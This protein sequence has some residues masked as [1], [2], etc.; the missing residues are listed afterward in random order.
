M[1]GKRF[2][3]GCMAAALL[4]F[5]SGA[6]ALDDD[7]PWIR[8]G[9]GVTVSP[10]F[11]DMTDDY[12]LDASGD[13]GW[14]DLNAGLEFPV[15]PAIS[16]IPYVAFYF[17]QISGDDDSFNIMI[18]PALAAKFIMGPMSSMTDYWYPEADFDTFIQLEVNY[19][20]PHTSSDE[21]EMDSAGFGFAGLL[22]IQLDYGYDLAAGYSYI[23]VE[24]DFENNR[25]LGG[26]LLRLNKSF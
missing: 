9:A 1:N 7:S 8:L 6:Q 22:G 3:L 18:V 2:A 19:G 4:A 23:P 26:F 10:E 21:F 16:V 12:N 20:F 25:N 17:N 15:T 13:W 11:D 14:L 5:P 24:D